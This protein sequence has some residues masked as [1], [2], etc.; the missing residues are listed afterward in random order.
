[1]RA[2][3]LQVGGRS[4]HALPLPEQRKLL[5]QPSR[6]KEIRLLLLLGL[7]TSHVRILQRPQQLISPLGR[8]LPT[9]TLSHRHHTGPPHIGCAWS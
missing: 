5:L 4:A 6:R 8:S 2:A 3:T 1:M 9:V 7:D